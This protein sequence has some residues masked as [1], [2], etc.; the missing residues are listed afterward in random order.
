MHVMSAFLFKIKKIENEYN[1][2]KKNVPRKTHIACMDL[3]VSLSSVQFQ[4]EVPFK[5]IKITDGD[6]YTKHTY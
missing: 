4:T 6:S 2:T 3:C 1:E 5:K